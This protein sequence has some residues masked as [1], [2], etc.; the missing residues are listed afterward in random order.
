VRD[1]ETGQIL[2]IGSSGWLPA[3]W[4]EYVPSGIWT[5]Y[6]DPTFY[7][8]PGPSDTVVRGVR[9][10]IFF[11]REDFESWFTRV[12]SSP[13]GFPWAVSEL[14]RQTVRTDVAPTIRPLLRAHR[15]AGTVDA[16]LRVFG[17]GGAASRNDGKGAQ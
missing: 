6:V 9:R 16:I 7:D 2:R 5:D 13:P 12:F 4:D 11:L 17:P 10:P 3:K 8:A 15:L 1:P 14:E